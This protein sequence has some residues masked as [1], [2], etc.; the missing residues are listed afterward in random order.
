[1]NSFQ[2]SIFVLSFT[3]F[4][5]VFGGMAQYFINDMNRI[6]NFPPEGNASADSQD[7]TECNSQI[8]ELEE[9]YFDLLSGNKEM[10]SYH[11]K[12]AETNH[13][14]SFVTDFPIET[15]CLYEKVDKRP[16]SVNVP[17]SKVKVNK[18]SENV[19]MKRLNFL[20]GLK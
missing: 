16:S 20:L 6:S 3:F 11:R 9:I 1:M 7:L 12:M 13:L 17:E 14:T 8:K 18:R 2:F 19:N 5:F 10:E 15:S 4:K